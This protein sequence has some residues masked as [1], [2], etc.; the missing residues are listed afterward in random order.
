MKVKKLFVLLL[1]SL[2]FVTFVGCATQEQES[3][4]EEDTNQEQTAEPPTQEPAEEV[5]LDGVTTPAEAKDGTYTKEGTAD[6]YG[7]VSYVTLGIADGKITKVDFDYKNGD[8]LKS[9][10]EE[11]KANMESAV[12]VKPEDFLA[13]YEAALL[14]AQDIAE[15]DTIAGA[16][17]SHDELVKLTQEALG[18]ATGK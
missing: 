2:L 12:G 3:T 18:E 9:T 16:T 13:E 14:E 7:W 11:Y 8:A 4:T 1:A 5:A 6:D 15:V 10:D 17:Q